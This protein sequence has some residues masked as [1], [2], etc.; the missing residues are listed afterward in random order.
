VRIPRIY[1]PASLTTDQIVELDAQAAAHLT[2]VLRLK[3]GDD[4]VVFNGEGGEYQATVESAERRSVSI[5]IG[6][7]VV[8][9][10]E[11]PLELILVQGVSRG[12]RMDFAV[13]K[14]VELGVS[15]IVP[16]LTERTVVN[17]KGERQQRRR[18]HWQSVA[19]SACEQCG[20]TIVPEVSPV[21]SLQDWF[22][23]S[24]EGTRFVL[25]HRAESGM[26]GSLNPQG[27]IS[28]LVGP[29]GG[30]SSSEIELAVSVGYFPLSLGPRILRTESAAVA[31][32][33]VMQW[34]WGDLNG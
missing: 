21:L 29:E 4:L 13:Q 25:H 5:R 32:L 6:K 22:N 12:E 33:S 23:T 28:L 8:R 26:I 17:I 14:A 24:N 3:T 7:F 11:S 10:V 15:R 27:P 9:S 2:R 18:D 20:R 30:L 34:V 1:Q 16:V 31:A 19:N